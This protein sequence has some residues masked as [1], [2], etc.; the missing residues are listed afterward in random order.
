MPGSQDYHE[1]LEDWVRE[2]SGAVRGYVL[3]LVRRPDVADDIVQDVFCRA[4]QARERYDDR[5]H[6]RAYLLRIA[7]RL[8]CDRGRRAG[9]EI[10]LPDDDWHDVQPTDR[11]VEPLSHLLQRETG[12]EM[13]AALQELTPMQQRVLL[14]RFYGDLDFAEIAATVGCPLNTALSHC[15]RGLL[16]LRQLLVESHD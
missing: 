5:G 14:L 6:A 11:S 3:T 2:H 8:V 15:R 7:D 16:K 13:T 4:W 1:R 10:D 9:R 12:A